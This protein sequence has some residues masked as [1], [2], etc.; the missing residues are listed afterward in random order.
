[1]LIY[2]AYYISLEGGPN[3]QTVGKMAL[4]IRVIDVG[5]DEP[6]GHYRAFIRCAGRIL[7]GTFLL[8]YLWMLWNEEKQTWHDKM[9]RS[10][11]VSA[12]G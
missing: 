1:V 8:G 9:A 2:A 6:I 12:P 5:S 4:G 10:V 7:S 11:V 3:G